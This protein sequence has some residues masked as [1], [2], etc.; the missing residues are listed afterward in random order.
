M[1]ILRFRGTKVLGIGLIVAVL[2]AGSAPVYAAMGGDPCTAE[3]LCDGKA[4]DG[5]TYGHLNGVPEIC[6]GEFSCKQMLWQPTRDKNSQF[7][8]GVKCDGVEE[9]GGGTPT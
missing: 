8:W 6:V 4:K 2:L 3:C 9:K 7:C 1:K 5:N